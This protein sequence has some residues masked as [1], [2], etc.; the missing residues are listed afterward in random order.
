MNEKQKN[1]LEY[2]LVDIAC[3]IDRVYFDHKTGNVNFRAYFVWESTQQ[4]PVFLGGQHKL[5]ITPKGE[6]LNR[7]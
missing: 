6:I 1:T 4:K 2:M 7:G 3:V 5:C